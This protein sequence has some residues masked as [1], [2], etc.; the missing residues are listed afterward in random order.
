MKTRLPTS[1]GRAAGAVLVL[2]GFGAPV[3][4][5]LWAVTGRL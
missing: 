4:L 3:A 5:I 1:T 2:F